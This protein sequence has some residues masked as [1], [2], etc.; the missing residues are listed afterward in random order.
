[1]ATYAERF[2]AFGLVA[3]NVDYDVVGPHLI[4]HKR[5]AR[6]QFIYNNRRARSKFLT[7]CSF[8]R[9]EGGKC[10]EKELN[11]LLLVMDKIHGASLS[12]ELLTCRSLRA[13]RSASML[14]C[15]RADEQTPKN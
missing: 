7:Q 5:L 13:A 3:D 4:I 8:H 12:D 14:R 9:I 6:F 15:D 11:R 2:Y 1:L 10:W